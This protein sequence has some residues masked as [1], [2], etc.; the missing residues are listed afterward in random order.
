MASKLTPEN[1]FATKIRLNLAV[2]PGIANPVSLAEDCTLVEDPNGPFVLYELTN[3]LPRVKLFSN[4]KTASVTTHETLDILVTPSFDPQQLLLVSGASSLPAPA[5]PGAD[6]GTAAIASYRSKRVVI[7]AEAK[8]PAIL[9]LNDRIAPQWAAKVDGK[10]VE[11]LQCNYI[12]RGVFLDKGKH[13]VEFR[14]EPKVTTLYASLAAWAVGILLAGFLVATHRK[15]A[16]GA[17]AV[18]EPPN[19]AASKGSDAPKA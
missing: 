1:G 16:D 4:W 8:T 9:L 5:Q 12:M 17:S 6:P 13:T 2:K 14:F 10:P 7:D 18:P 19:K 3:A 15:S 11:I